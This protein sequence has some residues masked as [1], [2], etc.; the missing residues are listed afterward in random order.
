MEKINTLIIDD[1]DN[2][3]DTLVEQLSFFPFISIIDTFNN[4]FESKTTF[5]SEKIDLVFLDIQLEKENGLEVAESIKNYQKIQKLFL[6]LLSQN[7]R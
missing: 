7:M 5:A 6:S 1:D 2:F 4:F 3:I